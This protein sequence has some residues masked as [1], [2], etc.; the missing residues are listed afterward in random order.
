MS[1]HSHANLVMACLQVLWGKR[2]FAWKNN[3]G[4]A[5]IHK[6]FVRFGEPGSPDI[7]GMLPNGQFLGVECKIGRD[8]LSL[9]QREF[10]QKITDNG[11][12]VVVAHDSV[13]DLLNAL[14]ARE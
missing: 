13:D 14:E 4:S 8:I 6:R 3:S 7:I 1:K 11:G 2:I 12:M 5:L 9:K 10:H